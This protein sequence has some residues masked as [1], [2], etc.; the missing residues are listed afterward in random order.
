[1]NA[2]AGIDA[3]RST[4]AILCD[5]VDVA[6][7]Q[8][9]KPSTESGEQLV[10]LHAELER[11]LKRSPEGP[12]VQWED[13]LLADVLCRLEAA[14]GFGNVTTRYAQLAGVLLPMA[15]ENLYAALRAPA[16]TIETTSTGRNG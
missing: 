11:A 2:H 15:Q 6:Q 3:P 9:F 16:P 8:L 12:R 13:F 1:M 5:L 10:A 14:R 4:K 7:R